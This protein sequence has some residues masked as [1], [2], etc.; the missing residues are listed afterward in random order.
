M[1]AKKLTAQQKAERARS[2]QRRIAKMDPISRSTIRG[3][4]SIP[5][6]SKNKNP[7]KYVR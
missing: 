3:K 1:K 6:P 5:V 2:R 4:G 7:R